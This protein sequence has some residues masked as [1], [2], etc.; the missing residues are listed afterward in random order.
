LRSAASPAGFPGFAAAGG[1]PPG[2][3]CPL[4]DCPPG[5]WLDWLELDW[6]EFDA[7]LEG[8]CA[9]LVNGDLL[10][11]PLPNPVEPLVACHPLPLWLADVLAGALAGLLDCLLG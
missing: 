6:L 9:S 4:P 11:T 10:G 8:F 3:F 7:L 5:D 2:L 1:A